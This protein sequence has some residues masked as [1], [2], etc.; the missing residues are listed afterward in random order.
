MFIQ[1]S[2]LNIAIWRGKFARGVYT[3]RPEKSK[4]LIG[5]SVTKISRLTSINRQTTRLQSLRITDLRPPTASQFFANG[6]KV[7]VTNIVEAYRT[8]TGA[9]RARV[10]R[11]ARPLKPPRPRDRPAKGA[12][13]D[14]GA[15][16]RSARRPPCGA[17]TGAPAPPNAEQP[18]IT[19]SSVAE[20]GK[21]RDAVVLDV[22]RP[23]HAYSTDD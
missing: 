13:R 8:A 3:W 17:F 5:A 7:T 9:A 19:T 14:T 21:A 22:M 18:T 23:F 4:S 6:D 12:V 20:R 15:E 2:P 16:L 11:F 10:S 1:I